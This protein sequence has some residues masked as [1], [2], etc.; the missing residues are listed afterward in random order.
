MSVSCTT[1][2]ACTAVGTYQIVNGT[3]VTLAEVWDGSTWSIEFDSE[4]PPDGDMP[5]WMA[6]RAGAPPPAKELVSA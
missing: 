3:S 4:V 2:T 6:F 5:S 1:T